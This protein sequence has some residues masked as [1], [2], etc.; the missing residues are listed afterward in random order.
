MKIIL[1]LLLWFQLHLDVKKVRKLISKTVNHVTSS[2]VHN[3]LW[4]QKK[5]E[6]VFLYFF[7]SYVRES[8]VINWVAHS[9]HLPRGQTK[10]TR[11]R[12]ASLQLSAA[13]YKS[14]ISKNL[15]HLLIVIFFSKQR[16]ISN[17]SLII[18]VFQD[19]A[20]Y[21]GKLW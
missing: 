11:K 5:Y 15:I 9:V 2:P 6:I 14:F 21:T 3:N 10:D 7:I 8:K 16:L 12:W 18:N 1:L 19:T 13:P 20:I 17:L 4:L